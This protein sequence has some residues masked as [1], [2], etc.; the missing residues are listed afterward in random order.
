MIN[1]I[2]GDLVYIQG[3]KAILASNGIEFIIIISSQTASHLSQLQGAERKN[4]RILTYLQ[5]REDAMTLFGFC[6]ENEREL[7]LQLIGVSGI[8]PKQAL[9]ILSG[10]MVNDF[11]KALDDND[12]DFLSKI[13]GLGKKTSQKIILALRDKLVITQES[14]EGKSGALY[15]TKGSQYEDLIVAL[16]QMGYDK[17]KVQNI[18]EELVKNKKDILKDKNNHE[19]EE[20]LFRQAILLLG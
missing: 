6:D 16:S 10:V 18:I 17:K 3:Q 19:S 9:K 14:Q 12:I 5:H 8:G 7:F 4:V 1:A 15:S 2:T 20:Y 13:P 11:L